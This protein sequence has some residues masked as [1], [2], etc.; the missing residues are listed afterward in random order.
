M[1]SD[2][3]GQDVES[4]L[5]AN[6]A[7]SIRE[8]A[9]SDAEAIVSLMRQL[10]YEVTPAHIRDRLQAFATSPTDQ[11]IVACIGAAVVG[12]ISLHAV[13]LLHSVGALGRITSLVVA[14]RYRGSGAGGALIAAAEPWFRA[15]GCV[16]IEVTSADHRIDAHRF[17]ANRGFRRDGQR[18]SKPLPPPP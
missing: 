2:R 16:K 10:G 18:F 8:A 7:L 6:R 13:P 9:A 3:L 14:E 15:A 1:D 11:L 17:Y 12:S 4:A 5:R